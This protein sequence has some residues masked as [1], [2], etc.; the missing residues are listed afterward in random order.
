VA[1]VSLLEEGGDRA[2]T[3]LSV[4]Q[5]FAPAAHAMAAGGHALLHAYQGHANAR[6][7]A[8]AGTRSFLWTAF[9]GLLEA[10]LAELPAPARPAPALTAGL[11]PA[12][13][14]AASI[15][16]DQVADGDPRARL[17]L[18][19]LDP[20]GPRAAARVDDLLTDRR[21]TWALGS[22]RLD[23][24]DCPCPC[25]LPEP[26]ARELTVSALVS[27]ARA[28]PLPLPPAA[29]LLLL[30]SPLL[31][32]HLASRCGDPLLRLP[33]LPPAHALLFAIAEEH[34]DGAYWECHPLH[35]ETAEGDDEDADRAP[36]APL[37]SEAAHAGCHDDC[38][39]CSCPP[40]P[41]AAPPLRLSLPTAR[42]AVRRWRELRAEGG[43]EGGG[44]AAALSRVWEAARGRLEGNLRESVARAVGAEA[45]ADAG[46]GAETEGGAGAGAV[47]VCLEDV[48][49]LRRAVRL[50]DQEEREDE[51]LPSP[52]AAP[53]SPSAPASVSACVSAGPLR[54]PVRVPA[55]EEAAARALLA[56]GFLE[57][58]G[59]EVL[60][61]VV[62]AEVV[63][64]R[65]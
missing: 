46:A 29:L 52:A 61:A 44:D 21:L 30:R 48:L 59:G 54:L 18:R 5:S 37:P 11:A 32:R 60:D 62:D 3:D 41:P 35:A 64:L 8:R 10:C 22:P 45:G 25:P 43:G 55:D 1:L 39:L 19:L 58:P 26:L 15:L 53:A 42:H 57:A 34:A 51:V 12:F 47:L 28:L 7:L 14:L 23:N 27:L 2:A 33:L 4:L 36:A 24:R 20:E 13:A 31:R 6:V 63:L 50:A 17:L 65:E 16:M 38:L 9:G 40:A 49:A 56:L